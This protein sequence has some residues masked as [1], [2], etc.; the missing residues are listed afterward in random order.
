M[1]PRAPPWACSPR[2]GWGSFQDAAGVV[3]L[4]VAGLGAYCVG[5]F[6]L[7]GQLHRAV[8]PTFR[9]AQGRAA[10]S[11]EAANPTEGVIQEP[12]VRRT[13]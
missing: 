9:R 12:G 8:L 3:G 10:V 11:A 5:A 1:E 4:V 2:R 6:E 13:T 7:E